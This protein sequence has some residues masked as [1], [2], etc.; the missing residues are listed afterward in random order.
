MRL[1]S[2]RDRADAKRT[3]GSAPNQPAFANPDGPRM[4]EDH[5]EVRRISYQ[6]AIDDADTDEMYCD[7]GVGD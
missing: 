4:L 2:D 5:S 1:T 3:T 7:L 6:C